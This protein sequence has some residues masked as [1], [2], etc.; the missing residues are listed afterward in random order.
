MWIL[1]GSVSSA[2]LDLF[3]KLFPSSGAGEDAVALAAS[4][5]VIDVV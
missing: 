5:G 1:C 3:S 2:S 4:F